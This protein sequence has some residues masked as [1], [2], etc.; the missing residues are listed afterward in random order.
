MTDSEYQQMLINMMFNPP[1]AS[2]GTD[3]AQLLQ[4]QAILAQQEAAQV[5]Q[6][7]QEAAAQERR[8]QEEEHSL[9]ESTHGLAA[10]AAN[11]PW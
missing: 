6:A 10:V 8:R 5:A 11:R 7:Q 1:T 9:L 3:Y 4:A 2:G